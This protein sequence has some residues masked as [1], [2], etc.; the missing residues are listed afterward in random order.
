MADHVEKLERLQRLRESGAITDAEFEREKAA[1]LTPPAGEA[2]ATSGQ[3]RM[4]LAAAAVAIVLAAI[5]AIFFLRRESGAEGN[6]SRS[7]NLAEAAAPN[8]NRVA[9]APPEP[10]IRSRPQAEQLATAFRAAF[11]S[12]RRATRA[13]EGDTVTYT[14]GGL[15]WIGQRAVLVSP[16]RNGQDCHACSG[17]LA[18]H[19]LEADGAGLRVTGEW[20]DGGAGAGWGAP[21]DWAFS[22]RLTDEPSLES[23]SGDMGQGVSC[24]FVSYYELG[25]RGPHEVARIQTSYGDGGTIMV[26][27]GQPETSLEGNIR[28]VVKGRSFDVV[29]TGTDRFTEHYVRRGDRY[30]LSSGKSRLSC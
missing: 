19:Y 14:P 3:S 16:G 1:L 28:N 25:P 8:A 20:L 10:A 18:V 27:D 5:L 13:V 2:A 26:A 4:W 9:P 24:G 12:D 29:Y 30:V 15:R 21:P 7:A 22:T 17:R 6:E 23:S 11:G